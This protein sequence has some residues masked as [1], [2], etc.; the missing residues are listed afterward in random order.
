MSS[1]RHI[2]RQMARNATKQALMDHVLTCPKCTKPL[3]RKGL[4]SKKVICAACG[5]KGQLK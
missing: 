4:L 1:V 2:R 5:W 3:W